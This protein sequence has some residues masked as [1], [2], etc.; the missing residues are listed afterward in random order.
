M[1]KGLSDTKRYKEINGDKI[2][3]ALEVYQDM[4]VTKG[5]EAGTPDNF[6]IKKGDFMFKEYGKM[7]KLKYISKDEFEKKYS[8]LKKIGF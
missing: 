2:I 5:E 1:N 6:V 3:V 8:K 4:I 7:G